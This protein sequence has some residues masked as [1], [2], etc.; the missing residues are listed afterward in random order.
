MTGWANPSALL[1]MQSWI[2]ALFALS[3]I[4]AAWRL[5]VFAV[6]GIAVG[7]WLVLVRVSELPSYLS[8]SPRTCINCHVMVPQY[9]TWQRS[10]HF[11]FATCNDCHVPHENEMRKYAFK[12]RDGLRHATIFAWRLE[13]QVIRAT[14]ESRHVIETNCRRC[15]QQT[16]SSVPAL[17]GNGRN[18]GDCHS[19][20]HGKVHSLASTPNVPVPRL[21]P[22]TS[23]PYGEEWE[24][25]TIL[26][27]RS[28]R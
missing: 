22:V 26:D 12:A 21:P 25:G 20:P 18:C 13:P 17:H 15:H 24:K 5:P 7:L 27:R 3:F 1:L 6:F 8:D 14:R 23:W 10:S 11:H 19:V 2:R 16:I 4:P 28:K 9:V